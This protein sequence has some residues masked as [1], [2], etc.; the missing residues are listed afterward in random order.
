MPA[1]GITPGPVPAPAI[2]SYLPP[3]TEPVT[4][5]NGRNPPYVG[6]VDCKPCI[7]CCSAAIWPANPLGSNVGI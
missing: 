5:G 4:V 1:V 6:V 7:C 3:F 2:L